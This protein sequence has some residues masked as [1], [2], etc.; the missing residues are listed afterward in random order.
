MGIEHEFDIFI[1]SDDISINNAELIKGDSYGCYIEFKTKQKKT[2]DVVFVLQPDWSDASIKEIKAK[3]NGE[4]IDT[5]I[6]SKYLYKIV[7]RCS[8]TITSNS[9]LELFSDTN[10]EM[11][12]KYPFVS[13]NLNKK[14]Y[15]IVKCGYSYVHVNSPIENGDKLLFCDEEYSNYETES[16]DDDYN[17]DE[18]DY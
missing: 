16:D 6:V 4:I 8:F 9:I 15:K 1:V 11:S 12:D 10:K 2:I 5:T 7:Q 13:I 18:Y 14:K 3:L 17:D